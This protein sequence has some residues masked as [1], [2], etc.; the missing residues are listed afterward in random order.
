MEYTLIAWHKHLFLFLHKITMRYPEWKNAITF[1]AEELD[2]WVIL[3][4]IAFFLFLLFR[5]LQHHSRREFFS[6]IREGVRIGVAILGGWV[7][8][9]ILKQIIHAPRPYLRFPHEVTRLFDYGGYDS[10][11]SGHATLFMALA[12]VIYFHHRWLGIL[13]F[14]FAIIIAIAR[15]IAGVHFPVDILVGWILGG[16]VAYWSYTHILRS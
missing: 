10:F 14:V 7:I 5:S 9:S 16:G 6:M 4:A 12:I 1:I 8:S 2:T 15:V 13:F 11:P 3:F